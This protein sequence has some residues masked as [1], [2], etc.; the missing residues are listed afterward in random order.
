MSEAPPTVHVV[1]DDPAIR[2]SLFRLLSSA[3]YSCSCHESAEAFFKEYTPG[4]SGCVLI[5][6]DLPGVDGF[7]VQE[8]L[9]SSGTGLPVLFLTGTG[10]IPA[11]VRAMKAGAVDFLTKPADASALLSAVEKALAFDDATRAVKST[12]VDLV[13]RLE[14]LTPRERQVL[15]LVVIGRQNKQI[16]AELG[17]AEKTIKVHR[18]RMMRK[19]RMPSLAELVRAMVGLDVESKK[20]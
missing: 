1:D 10:N 6:L 7:A 17:T 11:S 9:S 8:S 20:S 13:E 14:T 18:S 19:M 4:G 3:G 12:C 2:K 16:A 5:D 15:D